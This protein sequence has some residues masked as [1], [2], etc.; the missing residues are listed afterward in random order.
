MAGLAYIDPDQVQAHLGDM[1]V[2]STIQL[3]AVA[4]DAADE[5]NVRLGERYVV[6]LD[7]DAA[8]LL[9]HHRRLVEQINAR[10]AAGRLIM[11]IA[12]PS[13]D[14]DLHNYGKYL[15][16]LAMGDLD[17]IVSGRVLLGGQEDSAVTTDPDAWRGPSIFNQ[18]EESG[19]EAYVE[20][21]Y[22]GNWNSWWQPGPLP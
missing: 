20:S 16:D 10:L 22:G 8:A 9:P 15:V 13:E 6:P 11:A 5:M 7:L 14:R 2:S 19:V 12:S 18:D 4:A 3:D 1:A 21:F 17:L